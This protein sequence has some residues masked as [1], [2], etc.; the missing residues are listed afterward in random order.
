MWPV[1]V[2]GYRKV[3]GVKGWVGQQCFVAASCRVHVEYQKS[4]QSVALCCAHDWPL[5]ELT[6]HGKTKR[7]LF[8]C[9]VIQDSEKWLQVKIK[10]HVVARHQR[11]QH[12]Q[13]KMICR[14]FTVAHIYA[15]KN[16]Q[17]ELI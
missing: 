7:L 3:D 1:H 9:V 16:L 14:F 6:S 4:A 12:N 2:V 10:W 5:L 17:G 11:T 8:S 15:T 13:F